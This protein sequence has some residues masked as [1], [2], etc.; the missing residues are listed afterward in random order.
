MSPQSVVPAALPLVG[1][2]RWRETLRNG[3]HRSLVMPRGSLLQ[4]T[5]LTGGA[6]LACVFYN[7]RQ[8]L[9][10]YNMADTLKAQHTARLTQA[11]VLYSDMGRIL[12]SIVSDTCGWHDPIGG[13]SN[14]AGVRAQYGA[15]SYALH[16]NDRYLNGLDSLL[17]E[18]AKH[19]LGLRDLVAGVNFFSRLAADEAGSLTFVAGNSPPGATVSLRF[20]MPTL[21]V[22]STAP[23]PYDPATTYDPRPVELA[24]GTALPVAADDLC[25]NSCPENQRGFINTE[26]F[27]LNGDT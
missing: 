1:D 17:V 19:G 9:E 10:R 13:I 7:A 14:E 2:F 22:L 12:C 25:R 26:R 20:E 21:V 6:N 16:R 15:S 18:M 23:H 3:A 11:H 8:P 5:D 24:V 4:F 27:A